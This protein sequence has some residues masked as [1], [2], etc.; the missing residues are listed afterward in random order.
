MQNLINANQSYTGLVQKYIGSAY[1]TVKLVAEHLGILEE[2]QRSIASG[3]LKQVAKHL[4]KLKELAG[5]LRDFEKAYLGSHTTAPLTDN[6]GGTIP[7]G[8]MYYNAKE[9]RLYIM[10]DGTWNPIGSNK[11]ILYNFK[12]TAADITPAGN[13]FTFNSAYHPGNN[14]LMVFVNAT[15]QY[16]V[17]A[18]TPDGA[19]Q[20]TDEHS[21]FFP[22][23]ILEDGDNVTIFKGEVV[24]AMEHVISAD[25]QIYQTQMQGEKI[26]TLPGGMSYKP[27]IHNLEVFVDGIRQI[28]GVDYTE[29]SKTSVTFRT[30]LPQ[31][32]I[33]QFKH[34]SVIA[35]NV[36]GNTMATPVTVFNTLGEFEL[37]R[38]ELQQDHIVIVIDGKTPGDNDGGIFVYDNTLNRNLA[39][40]RSIIDAT[41][42]MTVQG[43]GTGMGCWRI[44]HNSSGI[45]NDG[46][47]N[48]SINMSVKHMYGTALPTA[49]TYGKGDIIWN[50]NPVAGGTVGWVCTAAGSP[51]TWKSFGTIGT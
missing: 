36:P 42:T 1:D 45:W 24:H 27:G 28:A 49:G 48:K 5:Y 13:T 3:D 51:G 2:L 20:E 10:D 38:S 15:F 11:N 32:V 12:L 17:T 35:S 7:D 8:A 43:T 34:G 26:I 47:N 46:S 16:P 50:T 44:I 31:G 6:S 22:A 9:H 29:T 33:L 39:N 41:V 40:G 18:S 30:A 23:G 37:R 25:V 4:D 21:I 14:Q 19:Y